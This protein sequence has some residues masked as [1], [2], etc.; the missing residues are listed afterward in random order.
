M[1]S[2]T[3]EKIRNIAMVGHGGEGKTSLTEAMLFGAGAT[4]RLGR[5]DDGTATTDYD[6]EETKRHISIGA[7]LAPFDWK[8]TK[9]NVIDTPGYFDFIGEVVQAMNAA[10]AAVIVVGAVSG[11]TVGTEKAMDMCKKGGIPKMIVVNRM[12]AE[13]ANYDKVVESLKAK[14]GNVISPIELP[15]MNDGKFVGYVDIV[16]QTAKLF[17]G[18][19]VKDTAIPASMEVEAAAYREAI[20]EAAAENDEELMEK[21]F[22]GEELTE[23]ELLKGIRM[24]IRVGS[25]A[26]VFCAAAAA[27]LGIAVLCDYV[28]D[29]MPSAAESIAKKGINP[30][31]DAAIVRNVSDNEPLSAFVFKTVADPFVGK[32]S[33]IKILS[34]V[35]SADKPLYNANTEKSEKIGTLYIM[36]G[37]KTYPVDELRAGD[38]GALAKLQYTMTGNTLCDPA[39]PIMFPGIE[40]PAPAIALAVSAKKNGEEDKV[41]GGFNKLL[42]EDLT[43]KLEKRADTGDMLMAGIGEMHLDVLCAKLR[44]KFNVEAKL[45]NPKVPYRETIRKSAKAQG[46]HKKQSGGHGQFGDVWIEFEPI[47]D[48]SAE[49]EFVDK[50]VGGVVPRNYIPAVEKGLREAVVKGVLAG[51]PMINIR[52]ILYFGSYHAVD[53]NEMA[54]RTAARLAYKKGCAEANPVLLEPIYR[55]EV[56]VPDEFMGDIIGDMNR[57]RG[58]I[59]GMNPTEDGQQQVVAEVPLAEMFKYATDLRSMTQ[60]RGWFTSAYERYED[61]PGNISAKIIEQAK[62]DLEEEEE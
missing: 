30:K 2:N 17:D 59:M 41:F 46:R 49:F 32:I 14:Y 57:R 5:V 53:S 44:N 48:G 16:K 55:Y 27:Q 37:K 28:V 8:G 25:I 18:K 34:G 10:D 45:E 43:F 4:D 29:Y 51:C 62:K 26:P 38:I 20:V 21:F 50:I 35:I 15:I 19:N 31:N 12:D 58:R 23:E 7:S 61:V 22:G 54:F 24:G 40:F 11:L 9:I 56:C 42:E 1:K 39:Q 36:K 33:L 3:A 13:N 6:P 52:C 47:L 60:G